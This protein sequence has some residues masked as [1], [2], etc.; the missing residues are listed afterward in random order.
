MKSLLV[1]AVCVTVLS[2][3]AGCEVMGPSVKVEPP[4]VR[5]DGV[6]VEDNARHCPPGQAKKGRC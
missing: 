4:K 5:V 3:L 6:R 1:L 2:G